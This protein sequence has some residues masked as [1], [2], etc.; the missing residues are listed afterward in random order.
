LVLVVVPIE[1]PLGLVFVPL[2]V[3]LA[4]V[5][6]PP[7]LPLV[8]VFVPPVVPLVLVF[9][10]PAVPL[11]LVFVPPAVPLALVFVPPAV[12]GTPEPLMVIVTGPLPGVLLEVVCP[13]R[14][15]AGLLLLATLAGLFPLPDP[16]LAL[17][18]FS[19]LRVVPC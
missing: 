17:H 1:L 13:G 9:V 11:V 15:V 2:E 5:F 8:L 16:S 18:K 12:V 4:L 3:P 6:V 19:K 10:P 7:V 14:V